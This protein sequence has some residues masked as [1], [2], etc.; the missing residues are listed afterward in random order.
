MSAAG[1]SREPSR[2]G[3][4]PRGAGLAVLA[5]LVLAACGSG[6]LLVGD[7][8]RDAGPG[9]G[10]SPL[11]AG[12]SPTDASSDATDSAVDAPVDA[13]ADVTCPTLSPPG[14]G[15]CDGGPFAPRYR[16]DGCING[17]VCTPA[18]CTDGGG[19]CVALTPTACASG[20]F[21]DAA[22]YSCGGGL[23]VACCLPGAGP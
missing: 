11:D 6:D 13:P 12:P 8:T 5:S 15:F 16:A 4:F 22:K 3:A 17:F 2:A 7:D 1:S 10:P 23:G 20:H 9:P 19:T 14:P 21:G 18:S